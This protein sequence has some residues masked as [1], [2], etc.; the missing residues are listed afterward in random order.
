MIVP[1]LLWMLAVCAGADPRPAV[2]EVV[3]P[4]DR[5]DLLA[6]GATSGRMKLF[7]NGTHS[8]NR[9]DPADGPFY[10]DPQPIYSVAVQS[11]K[12]GQRV[13][14]DAG[15]V[16]WPGPIDTL[17]GEFEVQ[18]VFD[19]HHTE[20][21]HHSPGN[22]YSKPVT[23]R[24]GPEAGAAPLLELTEVVPPIQPNAIDH[25][26]WIDEISPMLT[27]ATG[28]PTH[29]R[30]AVILPHGYD[31]IN[32]PRR[33]WPTIYVI[34]GFGGRFTD[35]DSYV[36]MLG[37]SNLGAVPQAVWVLLDPESPLGHH[38][39]AD[40]QLNGPCGTALVKELIPL[41]EERF[42]LIRSPDARLLTGHSSGGWSSLWLQLTH[43]DFFGGCWSSS[44]DPVDFSA[45]Q[46]S[47]MYHDDN[48]F[49]DGQGRPI[50]SYRKPIGPQDDQVLMTV[51]QEVGMERALDP[52]G[53]SGEQWDS[54][55]ACFGAP[56]ARPGLPRRAFD[57]VTGAIQHAVIDTHWSRFDVTKLVAQRWR[58]L[59]PVI[60]DKVHVLVGSRDSFYLERAVERLIARIAALRAEDARR[61][62][63]PP[64]GG[65]GFIEIIPGATHGT[66]AVIARGRFA[67][68]MR[69][70]L[71][72][73]GFGE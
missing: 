6:A 10:E 34:P 65:G 43:P 45:F 63:A 48:V 7:L 47:D 51:Q 71:K 19:A 16:G 26:V 35:V 58:E 62:V 15:A 27:Q 38:G 9:G 53:A 37:A 11:L 28:R 72:S 66:A 29:H 12:P 32:H 64:A 50:A 14:F 13:A 46:L 22:L 73:K 57:P 21:G 2:I 69:E 70:Y 5:Q 24:L 18:A 4:A 49:V 41:L 1:A 25:V 61:G 59:A 60:A 30:A 40:S 68:S 3:V 42:R 44:P 17:V 20:R 67:L 55:N 54:W 8:K 39:F 52:D 36:H 33:I 56:G 31:N 23:V